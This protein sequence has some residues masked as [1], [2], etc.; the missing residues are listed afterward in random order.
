M[1]QIFQ[2]FHRG[3]R[4]CSSLVNWY[5]RMMNNPS[6]ARRALSLAAFFG[7]VFLSLLGL[8]EIIDPYP[9]QGW[10]YLRLSL[11]DFGIF[12]I[13]TFVVLVG[14][15]PLASPLSLLIMTGAAAYGPFPA[16]VL[17][18]IGSLIN[19]NL[20]FF[21]V[22]ALSIDR[23]W[24][25]DS[26]A[27]R[28]RSA[29]REYGFQLVLVLQLVTIIPFTVINSAAAAAGIRWRDFMKATLV[30]IVPTIVIYSLLGDIVAERFFSP[31]IYFA[32]IGVVALS[33]FALA[34]HKKNVQLRFKRSL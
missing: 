32:L 7:I 31:R 14:I 34:V 2:V 4:T 12:G 27:Y 5:I 16:M 33:I 15:L 30:G 28:Y 17:S 29:I 9:L 19:A 25:P 23:A 22:K 21:L 6:P 13:V 10:I 26:Y 8:F 20:V 11:Q 18:Y 24:S 1:K 3:W